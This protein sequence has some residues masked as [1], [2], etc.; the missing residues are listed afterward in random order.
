VAVARAFDG[1]VVN[2]DSMQVYRE[3]AVLSARPTLPGMGGVEHRLYGVLPAAQACSAAAWAAMA[4]REVAAARR[5]GRMPIVV[6][7]T[8]L[9]LRALL[10][11]MAPVPDVPEAIRMRVRSRLEREGAAA[12]H[13]AL[14]RLDPEGA[15]RLRPTDSQR[16]VRALEVAE[17]TGRPLRHW[18]GLPPEGG[19]DG[20][21][22][23][24]VLDP[25]RAWMHRRCDARVRAMVVRGAADEAAAV[26][27][28][29]LDPALPAMKTL[30]LQPFLNYARGRASLAEA[31]ERTQAATRQYAKRQATWFRHQMKDAL[32][33]AATSEAARQRAV[34][35]AVG[36]FVS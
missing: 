13:G 20:P 16:I 2:A 18:H 31:I 29:G 8:G 15:E 35:A 26:G 25:P 33:V 17:A 28:L 3:I 36:R 34:L 32:R 22:L 23:A 21:V 19:H 1:I 5:A 30:G 14:R 27:G 24:V 9:Y 10:H 4:R 12:L 7:G 6:G 11:G